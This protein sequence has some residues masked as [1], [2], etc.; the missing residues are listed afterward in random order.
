MTADILIVDDEAD[1]R[2]QIAGI[3][4][5]EGYRARQAA[6]AGEA[7][8]SIRQK[9]P[10]CVLLDIWL[11]G[12]T[13]GLKLLERFHAD[14]PDMPVVMITGHGTVETAVVAIKKGA[15]DFIEKPFKTDRLLLILERA[16][17]AALLKRENAE[18]KSH[19]GPEWKLIGESH[20]I[21][22]VRQIVVK[23]APTG[24]RVLISGPPGSGKE[25]VARQIHLNSKRNKGPFV[26]LNCAIM[27]P[28][29]LEMELFGLAGE[30]VRPG[31]L[32]RAS[33][34]TLLLDEVAD[35]PFETQGKIVRVLQ[36]QTIERVGGGDRIQV[37]V[38][39]IAATNRDLEA[40]MEAGRFRHDLYYRLNVVPI[41]MPALKDRAADIPELVTHLM[42]RAA[43]ASGLPERVFGAD[44]MTTLQSYGWPGNVRQLRNV[45]DW[46]LI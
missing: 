10:D 45:I 32:E 22:H 29:R 17:E 18:L 38:R 13:D 5:D 33:G 26:I 30:D 27:R 3:L 34:G 21:H 6:V 9:L 25:V 23:V 7:L 16:I 12:P 43:N 40:E 35:M 37:D 2:T 20:A 19:S 28:E 14:H 4:E 1:I 15:Y 36:D 42:E 39:V 24:S 44:A 41:V 8:G 46:L 11:D 31:L